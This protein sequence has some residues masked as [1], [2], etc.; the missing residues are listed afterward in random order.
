MSQ[1]IA[2]ARTHD[3]WVRAIVVSGDLVSGLVVPGG[4]DLEFA[5]EAAGGGVDHA[6][7]E[8]LDQEQDVGS[9]VGS[10]EAD[11]T[12]F[13]GDAQGDTAGFVDL[14]GAGAVVA[15][16]GA[17]VAGGAGFRASDADRSGHDEGVD[18]VVRTGT[19]DDAVAVADMLRELG[20]EQD[21]GVGDRLQWWTDDRSA[22][23]CQRLTSKARSTSRGAHPHQSF[24]APCGR[25]TWGDRIGEWFSRA[26]LRPVDGIGHFCPVEAPEAMAD[27]ITRALA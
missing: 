7:M 25:P 26:D 9:G 21:G 2:D 22:E 8:V 17:V 18:L 27:A 24:V 20:Y 3:V 19:V 1:D 13:P 16:A 4:V 14:V 6:D 12:E 10:A 11:V 15:V 23:W 5:E